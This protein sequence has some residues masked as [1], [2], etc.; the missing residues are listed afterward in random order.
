[1]PFLLLLLFFENN[2]K[3]EFLKTLFFLKSKIT[4]VDGNIA[5][6]NICSIL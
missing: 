3:Q 5:L 2:E 6:T 1:M 4:I